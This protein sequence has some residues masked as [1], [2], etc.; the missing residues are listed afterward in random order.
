VGDLARADD[1]GYIQIGGRKKEMI[2]SGGTNIYPAEI[3]QVMNAHPLVAESAVV[4]VPDP[5]WVESAC[6]F[7]PLKPGAQL[8]PEELAEFCRQSLSRYKVT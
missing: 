3:E 5:E 4:G 2:I 8:A 6:A 7:V 1:E